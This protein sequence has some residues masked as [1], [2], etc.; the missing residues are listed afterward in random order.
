[1]LP[2]DRKISSYRCDSCGWNEQEQKRRLEEGRGVDDGRG[3]K[4]L[5]FKPKQIH[6]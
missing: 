3:V 5:L 2:R 4:Y 1:M 6:V